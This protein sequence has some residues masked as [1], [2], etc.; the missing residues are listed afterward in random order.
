ME[1]SI[2]I[3]LGMKKISVGDTVTLNHPND[4]YVYVVMNVYGD[5]TIIARRPDSGTA[6]LF[7]LRKNGK[8][9]EQGQSAGGAYLTLGGAVDYQALEI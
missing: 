3:L 5:N 1:E 9:I 8:F 6:K 7:T 4:R 2:N